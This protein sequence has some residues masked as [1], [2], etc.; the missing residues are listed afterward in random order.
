MFESVLK[1]RDAAAPQVGMR[2][3]VS[4]AIHAAA[5]VALVVFYWVGTKQK[6]ETR[7]EVTFFSPNGQGKPG[8]PKIQKGN[9]M[10]QNMTPTPTQPV[11]KVF[12]T[13]PTKAAASAKPAAGA[14]DDTYGDVDGSDLGSTGGTKDGTE[15]AGTSTGTAS[16]PPPPAPTPAPQNQVIPFGPGMDRPVKTSG[17]QPALTREARDADSYG[18][19]IVQCT[20]DTGGSVSGC[21]IVKSLPFMD[22]V[23]LGA[24]SQWHFSPAKQNGAPVAVL[25]NIPFQFTKP[26]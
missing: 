1:P 13:N 11:K 18:K 8:P 4:V 7:P 10:S 9:P 17:P 3:T 23:V 24:V 22:E 20:I 6:E 14:P 25:Y 21:R 15:G 12:S 5:V 19:C 26:D 16:A 2:V